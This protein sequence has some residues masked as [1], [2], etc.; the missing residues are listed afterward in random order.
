M[1]VC[2]EILSEERCPGFLLEAVRSAIKK[3]RRVIK[4][5]MLGIP[6]NDCSSRSVWHAKGPFSA[7]PLE[8]SGKLKKKSLI[9][10]TAMMKRGPR[11]SGAQKSTVQKSTVPINLLSP[12]SE[13][14]ELSLRVLRRFVL[15]TDACPRKR[16]KPA[17]SKSS[18]KPL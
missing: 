6:V 10:F 12:A 7:S 17:D 4:A 15:L 18:V 8:N 1:C 14:C 2:R 13:I 11:C 5:K 3:R 9:F 16:N